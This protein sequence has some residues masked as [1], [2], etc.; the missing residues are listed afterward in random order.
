MGECDPLEAPGEAFARACR[1]VQGRGPRRNDVNR[2]LPAAQ[3]IPLA[4][5]MTGP[6]VQ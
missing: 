5:E 1:E 3:A 6:V 4:L 2:T